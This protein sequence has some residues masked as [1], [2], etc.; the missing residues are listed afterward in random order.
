MGERY[1]DQYPDS[2]MVPS[3]FPIMIFF[4][5]VNQTIFPVSQFLLNIVFNFFPFNQVA[6]FPL[7]IVTFFYLFFF[8]KPSSLKQMSEKVVIFV[9]ES[10][11]SFF[12]C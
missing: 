6:L 11:V 4:F 3:N 12:S 1:R 8:Y 7:L 9:F 2:P 5:V 10:I